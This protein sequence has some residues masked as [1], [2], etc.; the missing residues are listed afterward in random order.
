MY[1]TIQSTLAKFAKFAKFAKLAKSLNTRQIRQS[2]SQKFA[3][4]SPNLPERVTKIWQIFGEYSNLLNS[5]ASGH[6][7]VLSVDRNFHN[8][9]TKIFDTFQ[10]IE[11]FDQV[12]KF[13]R[14]FLA[15]DQNFNNAILTYFKLSINCQKRTYRFWQL[16][17]SF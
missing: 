1:K 15:L 16:I 10:L 14:Y 13:A 12:P 2:E 9:L 8:Q 17:K 3:Q 6:C 5:P 11:K 7:L 4:Y